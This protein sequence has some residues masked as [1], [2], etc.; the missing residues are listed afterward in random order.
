MQKKLLT[1]LS[2]TVKTLLLPTMPASNSQQSRINVLHP[3]DHITP[4][5][6]RGEKD[7]VLPKKLCGKKKTN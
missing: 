2:A 5:A 6:L 4:E 3:F 1:S 7:D